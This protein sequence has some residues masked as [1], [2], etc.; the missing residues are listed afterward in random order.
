MPH[1]AQARRAVWSD[2]RARCSVQRCSGWPVMAAILIT[3]WGIVFGVTG[4][5]FAGGGSAAN[6]VR[7]VIRP[8]RQATIATDA[9]LRTI[10]LPFRESERFKLGDTLAL[11]DCRRQRL[12]IFETHLHLRASCLRQA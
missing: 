8:I 9:P 11:F 3:L 1:L 10:E 5:A 2:L 6:P 7:G 12:K 4:S